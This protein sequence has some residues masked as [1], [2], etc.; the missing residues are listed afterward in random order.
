MSDEP[1]LEELQLL[2]VTPDHCRK[3]DKLAALIWVLREF[4]SEGQPSI[5]FASTRHHVEFLYS[6]LQ[7]AGLSVACVYGAMD[8]VEILIKHIQTFS[9][10]QFVKV[11]DL[12]NQLCLTCLRKQSAN[13]Y[14]KRQ[15][16]EL[17]LCRPSKKQAACSV[18]ML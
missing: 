13:L 12:P 6:I 14:S 1:S 18:C 7:A 8:Q 3:E 17:T 10:I 9:P 11:S 5:V 2:T 16:D 15:E 4:V